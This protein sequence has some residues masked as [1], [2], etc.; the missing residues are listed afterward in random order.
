MSSR[1]GKMPSRRSTVLHHHYAFDNTGPRTACKRFCRVSL[2]PELLTARLRLRAWRESDLEPFATLNA[3]PCVTRFLSRSLTREESDALAAQAQARI[4]ARGWGPWALEL[5]A[6]GAFIGFL[7]LA[8]PSFQAHFTPCVEILWR[9]ARPCWGAGLASEAARE[10]LGLAFGELALDEVV[11][12]TVPANYRSRALM[13]RLGLRH[14]AAGD[15]AHPRVPAEHPLSH[16]VLYRLSRKRW[17]DMQR[18]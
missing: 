12:F 11:S 3:D 13:E 8:V 4:E 2:M 6:T 17:Q 7:G 14:D 18:P 10:C 1:S 16:H 5:R 15:F 9:L